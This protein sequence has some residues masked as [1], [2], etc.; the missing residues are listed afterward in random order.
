MHRRRARPSSP[1]DRRSR[2]RSLGDA[3]STTSLVSPPI[4]WR[5]RSSPNAEDVALELDAAR[6]GGDVRAHAIVREL[7]NVCVFPNPANA[8]ELDAMAPSAGEVTEDERR[9]RCLAAAATAAYLRDVS[10]DARARGETAFATMVEA[11]ARA[12][13]AAHVKS[14]P[15]DVLA[16]FR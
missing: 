6:D 5:L 12:M 14:I 2:P 8:R 15:E 7:V 13:V 10:F 4:V 16:R 1:G 3:D 11:D 9:R